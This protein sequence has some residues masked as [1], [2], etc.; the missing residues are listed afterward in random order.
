MFKK[1]DWWLIGA[2]IFMAAA[3]LISLSSTK[4]ALFQIQLIWYALSFLI[5][6]FAAKINWRWLITQNWFLLSFYWLTIILL[7][8]AFFFRPIRG[9]QSWLIIGNFQ[10]QPSELAKISLIL[11]FASFFSRRYLEVSLIKNIAASFFYF[12]IPAALVAL[13]PALG[14]A[15]IFFGIWFS[16]LIVSGLKWQRIFASFLIFI[17]V[18][19]FLWMTFLRPYQKERV[20]GFIFPD[21][22]PLGTNYNVIQSKIAIG[23]AGLFGKGFQQGTQSRLGFLPE[24]QTDFIFSAFVEEWG[25]VGGLLLIAAFLLIIFRI[26]KIGIKSEGNCAKFI[27]LGAAIALGSQFF[28]N[29]G[30]CLGLSPVVGI[31]F[32][33]FSYG[34]SSLLTNALL[35]GIIQNIAIESSF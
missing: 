16:F 29:I 23:S 13:Q 3:S 34:G 31:T 28:F 22:N 21:R 10:F 25:L 15:I 26:I 12:F 2:L 30:S 18:F 8:A 27:C 33:F 35:I 1:L 17:L 20:L 14:M 7:I 6:F 32:P 24:A 9:A 5:I 4:P 19:S 11:I